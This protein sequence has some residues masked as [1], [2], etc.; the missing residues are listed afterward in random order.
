MIRS[1]FGDK[2]LFFRHDFMD[3]DLKV[4]PEWTPYVPRFDLDGG[5]CPYETMIKKMSS[6]TDGLW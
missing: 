4:R 6:V 5:K 3:D 2:N 1:E